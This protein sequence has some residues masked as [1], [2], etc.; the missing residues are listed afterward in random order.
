MSVFS[1]EIVKKLRPEQKPLNRSRRNVKVQPVDNERFYKAVVKIDPKIKY[2][3]V[4][5]SY[6]KDK[7]FYK[8]KRLWN[9]ILL[10]NKIYKA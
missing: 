10:Y 6:F 9:K 7:S 2:E 8:K 1:C 4:W 5:C 3:K